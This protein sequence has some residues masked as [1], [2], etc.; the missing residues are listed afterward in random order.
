MRGRTRRHRRKRGQ[1]A[2]RQKTSAALAAAVMALALLQV[3]RADET[4]TVSL[5]VER[6]DTFLNLFGSDW[7]KAYEQN[8]LTVFRQ[9]RPVTS[10]DV[11][12]EG[13]VVRVSSD[14]A[15]TPRAVARC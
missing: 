3:A 5:R 11:L 15:L 10:P 6:G 12:V 9:G 13:M 14:V 1:R 2:M 7:Q 8:R 4:R